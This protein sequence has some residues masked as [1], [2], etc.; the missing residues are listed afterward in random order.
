MVIGRGRPLFLLIGDAPVLLGDVERRNTLDHEVLY[1]RSADTKR[2]FCR[3]LSHRQ[4]CSNAC[5]GHRCFEKIEVSMAPE[6]QKILR[7]ECESKKRWLTEP[8]LLLVRTDSWLH[9][10]DILHMLD[11]A[12][13]HRR[14]FVVA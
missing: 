5:E 4:P 1:K 11:K 7:V 9:P 12:C 14:S 8:V 6:A 3:G 2:L 13:K 10:P